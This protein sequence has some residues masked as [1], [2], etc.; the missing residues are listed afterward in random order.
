M[1]AHRRICRTSSTRI[2]W[3][4]QA[5]VQGTAALDKLLCIRCAHTTQI[6]PCILIAMSA[7]KL[8][9]T[10]TYHR[11]RSAMHLHCATAAPQNWSSIARAVTVLV[12]ITQNLSQAQCVAWRCTYI[13]SPYASTGLT[14][15]IKKMVHSNY[16]MSLGHYTQHF[17]EDNNDQDATQGT[18][19]CA[20]HKSL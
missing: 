10:A 20:C 4:G 15:S 2:G 14:W 16:Y 1:P 19:L 9:G 13:C 11:W 5:A 18:S 7:L 3:S 17:I 12:I 8:F 6:L